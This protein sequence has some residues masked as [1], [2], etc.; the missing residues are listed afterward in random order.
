MPLTG[1]QKWRHGSISSTGSTDS[2]VSGTVPTASLSVATDDVVVYGK[3]LGIYLADSPYDL[4]GGLVDMALYTF[5]LRAS[6]EV[7]IK[8]WATGNQSFDIDAYGRGPISVELE[9]SWAKTSDIVGTGS[10]SDHWMADNA[11]N[12]YARIAATS[13]AEAQTS[14]PYSWTTDMPMRY[15]TRTEGE[16]GNNTLVV[17]TGHAFYDP[18]LF[19]GFFT[20]DVVNTLANTNF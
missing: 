9:C 14:I 16:S 15:Y 7:D 3:D 2:P 8:R 1:T 20:S 4:A 6:Q 18:D 19:D 17:L 10:E 5:T 12:R 11:V 13:T